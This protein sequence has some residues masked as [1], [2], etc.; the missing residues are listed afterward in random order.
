MIAWLVA[1]SQWILLQSKVQRVCAGLNVFMNPIE[2]VMY[3]IPIWL[4]LSNRS[5]NMYSMIRIKSILHKYLD[6]GNRNSR[7]KYIDFYTATIKPIT[8]LCKLNDN[9]KI[10]V[11]YDLNG[12]CICIMRM[13]CLTSKGFVLNTNFKRSN[14]IWMFCRLLWILSHTERP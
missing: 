7:M 13:K 8:D 11:I 10:N 3:S 2:F 5:C 14:V 6:N 1:F 4:T 12:R 9:F